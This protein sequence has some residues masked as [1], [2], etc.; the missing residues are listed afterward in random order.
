MKFNYQQTMQQAQNLEQLASDLR[1]K[2]KPAI[3]GVK[4]N[5]NAAWTG[6]SGKAFIRFLGEVES[7]MDAKAKYLKNVSDYL[8]KTAKK[9]KQ[10]EE[11]AKRSAAGIS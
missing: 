10:A 4:D 1:S 9:I 6:D 3:G 5:L 2:T 11:A 7:D 8:K